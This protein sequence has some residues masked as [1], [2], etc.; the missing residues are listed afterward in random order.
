MTTRDYIID[1]LN[2]IFLLFT[3]L[4]AFVYFFL[5]DRLGAVSR[6]MQALVPL[7]YF[8]TFFLIRFRYTRKTIRR[9][10]EEGRSRDVSLQLTYRDKIIDEL[11]IFSLPVIV[12]WVAH[13]KGVVDVYTVFQAALVFIIMF[14]WHNIL[15][16]KQG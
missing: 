5:G 14:T 1:F 10:N 3:I 15:F 9:M 4:F 13:L 7:S 11:L 2:Y 12:I 16:K 8:A 6:A